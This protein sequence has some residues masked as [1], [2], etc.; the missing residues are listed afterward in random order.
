MFDVRR[1]MFFW[2]ATG[3]LPLWE[4]PGKA[5]KYRRTPKLRG[6]YGEAFKLHSAFYVEPWAFTLQVAGI[7]GLFCSRLFSAAT[8][9]RD[10]DFSRTYF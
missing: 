4:Q 7:T 3:P 10:Y 2:S 5:A 8:G 1:S 9:R 6:H